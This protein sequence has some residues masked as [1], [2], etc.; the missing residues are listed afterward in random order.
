MLLSV[1]VVFMSGSSQIQTSSHMT[2]V[3][4]E[5]KAQ[6]DSH[7][8]KFGYLHIQMCRYIANSGFPSQWSVATPT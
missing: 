6:K 2:P 7:V 5:I 3:Q 1:H 8:I 4:F